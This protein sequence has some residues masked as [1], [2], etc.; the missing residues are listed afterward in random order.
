MGLFDSITIIRSMFK[1]LNNQDHSNKSTGQVQ[2][3]QK[4]VIKTPHMKAKLTIQSLNMK[5]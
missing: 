4:L 2:K 1:Q 5:S 3:L